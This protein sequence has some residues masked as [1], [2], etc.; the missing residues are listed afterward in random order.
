MDQT[1]LSFKNI[2]FDKSL[3][4]VSVVYSGPARVDHDEVVKREEAAYERGKQEATDVMNQQILHNR[5]EVH[6]LLGQTLEV[7]DEKVEKCMH[8]MLDEIPG[9]VTHIVRQLIKGIE[10]DGKAIQGIIDDVL[11]D[12]P[13]GKQPM[14]VYLSPR[15]LE[16][17]KTFTSELEQNYPNIS[18]QDDSEL[19]SGDCRA[20]SLFGA[21]DARMETK[22]KHI[23]DQLEG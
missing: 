16:V 9:L 7:M 1:V 8:D 23:Q 22:L 5:R 15:D 21:I 3:R 13:S 14:D 2:T 6:Q 20:E 17:F 4:E 19:S 12:L 18:F 10:L 11:H